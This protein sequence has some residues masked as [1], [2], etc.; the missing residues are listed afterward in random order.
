MRRGNNGRKEQAEER[1]F[2]HE[3]LQFAMGFH[4]FRKRIDPG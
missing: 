2:E 4:P 1:E 3:P